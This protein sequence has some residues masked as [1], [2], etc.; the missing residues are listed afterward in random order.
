MLSLP[1]CD[2]IVCL[3]NSSYCP[4]LQSISLP[5]FCINSLGLSYYTRNSLSV[6]APYNLINLVQILFLHNIF[7]PNN[8]P[9][10]C[11]W[12]ETSLL[13]YLISTQVFRL[14]TQKSPFFKFSG[15]GQLFYCY[16]ANI[17][18]IDQCA[19][20]IFQHVSPAVVRNMILTNTSSCL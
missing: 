9:R 16:L 14:N 7:L 20:K 10:K 5:Y 11:D 15:Y 19:S 17:G 1:M 3:F 2:V 18:Q 6:F 8:L 4:W 13:P 12:K